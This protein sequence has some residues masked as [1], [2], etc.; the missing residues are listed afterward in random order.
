MG[1]DKHLAPYVEE[2]EIHLAVAFFKDPQVYDLIAKV[3]G[4]AFP[5]P[6]FYA[7]KDEDPFFDR[8]DAFVPDAYVSTVNPLKN[9]SHV[10]PLFESGMLSIFAVSIKVFYVG[11][12]C[13]KS[14]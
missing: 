1:Y 5:V 7:K 9:A 3:F 8:C 12:W 2:G 11:R 13:D 14:A 6:L 4:I 10:S